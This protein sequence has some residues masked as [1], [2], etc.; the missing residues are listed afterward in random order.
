VAD[1]AR[2]S[3]N[4]AAKP[5]LVGEAIAR[6]PG[7]RI[8]GQTVNRNTRTMALRFIFA[9][10][11][12]GYFFGQLYRLKLSKGSNMYYTLRRS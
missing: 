9:F 5:L 3:Q 12:T 2:L 6:L 11:R 10:L 7:E 1:P 4:L 8:L